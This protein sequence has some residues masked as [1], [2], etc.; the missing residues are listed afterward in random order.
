MAKQIP[1]PPELQ[2]LIEKREQ[3][4]DRRKKE[5]APSPADR[6]KTADRRRTRRKQG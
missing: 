1:V 3:E 6:R 2:H 5:S 4:A